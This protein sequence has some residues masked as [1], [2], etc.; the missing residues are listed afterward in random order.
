[1]RNAGS[2]NV[3]YCYEIRNRP[4]I[5]AIFE[6][7]SQILRSLASR[8]PH[9]RISVYEYG[10]DPARPVFTRVDTAAGP[11]VRTEV[12]KPTEIAAVI[13]FESHRES[14]SK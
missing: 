1:M 3:W 4:K 10:S 14:P 13:Y 6:F 8:I 9:N 2:W 11:G 7:L 12:I 5:D